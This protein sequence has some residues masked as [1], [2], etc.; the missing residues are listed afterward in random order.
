[1][2]NDEAPSFREVL[3]N[4]IEADDISKWKKL[5][6]SGIYKGRSWFRIIN[7][8]VKIFTLFKFCGSKYLPHSWTPMKSYCTRCMCEPGNP[9]P[10]KE[11]K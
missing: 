3:A 6:T 9:Y 4:E 11:R 2:L 5:Q 1:M 7:E 10:M 8:S